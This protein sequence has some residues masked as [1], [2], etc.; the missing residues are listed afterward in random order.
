MTYQV[1]WVRLIGLSLGSTSASISTV[2]SAFFLGLALGSYLAERITR[3]RIDSLMPY[4]ILEVA[5]GLSGL[6]LLPLL[7]HLDHL[8]AMSPV[9][10]TELTLKF[11][12]SVL[13]LIVPTTCMGATF[14]VMASILIRRDSDIGARISELY[15]LNTIG[16][17]LGACLSGFVFIRLWGLDGAVYIAAGL[18]LT[19]AG[20]AFWLN[21]KWMLKPI[22][23]GGHDSREVDPAQDGIAPFRRAAL[24]ILFVTGF[25]AIA[26]QVGWTKFLAIFTGSTIYGFSAIL[27]VFLAGIAAGSWAIKRRIDDITSPQWVMAIGLVALGISLAL[28]RAGLSMLPQLQ[29]VLNGSNISASLEF[30]IR[31][32]ALFIVLFVPTFLFGAL[33]PLNLKIYCGGLTGVRA[34]IGKAYAVNTVASIVGA[35]FAGFWIIPAFGTN[36]LLT[37]IALLVLL[38][39]LIWLPSLPTSSTRVSIVLMAGMGV[40]ATYSLPRLSFENLISTVG[41]ATESASGR[42]P[43][44]LFLKEGK[45]GVIS[46][47]TYDGVSARLQSN[48]LNESEI[49]LT[50]PDTVLMVESFLGLIPYMLHKD[51]ESAFLIGYGGGITTQALVSTDL[52]SVRIVELEP[53]V[54][55]AGRTIAHGPAR[56]LTDTRVSLEFNDARNTLLVEDATYDLII[57]QP[58]H[59][60]VAGSANVFTQEFWE[61]AQSRLNE[62]GIFGQWVNLFQMDATTLR[63][64]LKSFYTVFPEGMTFANDDSGDLLL[65]GSDRPLI[66]D[67]DRMNRVLQDPRTQPRMARNGIHRAEDVIWYF[68]LSRR[69]AL[70]AAGDA[71]PNRDTNILSEV[72]L[73]LLRD[74]P[75]GKED[76]YRFVSDNF[77]LDIIPYLG[78]DPAG[79]LRRLADYYFHW[80]GYNLA[81][82]A[83]ERLRAL[84]EQFAREV[85]YEQAWR[86]RDYTRAFSLYLG[87]QT[88]PDAVHVWQ[89]TALAKLNKIDEARVAAARVENNVRRQ[90]IEARLH[91]LSGE[92][93]DHGD[94]ASAGGEARK[95]YLL[96]LA[97]S[98]LA[99]AGAAVIAEALDRNDD[100]RILRMLLQYHA[101]F[102][103]PASIDTIAKRLVVAIEANTAELGEIALTAL[104]TGSIELAKDAVAA[105]EAIDRQAAVLA[106]LHREIARY[107]AAKI[108]SIE[109][110]HLRN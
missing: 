17:V 67:Y 66:F 84:N 64:I 98:D 78:D 13:L 95:W 56:A 77:H 100:L 35:I 69:E 32:T 2:L 48:G 105:I 74:D 75:S 110:E 65:F 59:P 10:G 104:N 91:F 38:V 25:S 44:F 60:W 29:M 45:A 11:L 80:E 41:Y 52:E 12:L 89:A 83:A 53:A 96:E 34:R 54:V 62:G 108:S 20:L 16:A 1:A 58:S 4:V 92:W 33:F 97:K 70:A 15:S 82:M 71:T 19:V 42:T 49:N 5:V 26:T 55:E 9:F 18:N 3:N 99:G 102:G 68:A 46:L 7:L 27:T 6:I 73:S 30:T 79:K 37:A 90:D 24:V 87:H 86:L 50:N 28:T 57:S 76:P 21:K 51:P 40:F 85:S 47:T 31:Y 36:V 101:E 61:I 22:E 43:Q 109:H 72:R 93:P 88:W 107:S 81:S 14:P 103:D 23:S 63:S 8:M 39:S 94:W 106:E